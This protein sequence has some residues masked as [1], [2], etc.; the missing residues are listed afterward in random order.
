MR[1]A[2]N[3][4][5]QSQEMTLRDPERHAIQQVLSSAL[6]PPSSS[7]LPTVAFPPQTLVLVSEEGSPNHLTLYRGT[8]AS[9]S[10]DVRLLEDSMP[11]WLLSYLLQNRTPTMPQVSKVSFV[12]LPWVSKD[13]DV[14]TLPELLNTYVSTSHLEKETG[15]LIVFLILQ[16]SIEIDS[17][18]VPKSP[19]TRPSRKDIVLCFIEILNPLHLPGSRKTRQDQRIEGKFSATDVDYL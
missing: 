2:A 7:E 15:G 18:P 14:E 8:V 6:S 13:P 3:V 11:L 4:T 10:H 5:R 12:L 9:T 19:E 17:K 16:G 1:V